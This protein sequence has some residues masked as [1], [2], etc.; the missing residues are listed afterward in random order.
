MIASSLRWVLISR[1]TPSKP[2]PVDRMMSDTSAAVACPAKEAPPAAAAAD[3]A[4]PARVG[5]VAPV[6]AAD[7]PRVHGDAAPLSRRGA[8]VPGVTSASPGCKAP[9]SAR[10]KPAPPNEEPAL[11]TTPAAP[12]DPLRRVSDEVGGE[13]RVAAAARRLL[14]IGSVDCAATVG[15]GSVVRGPALGVLCPSTARCC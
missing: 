4:P 14:L 13:Q 7:L 12:V 9:P 10:A 8:A 15:V 2:T 5:G 6:A 1:R 3:E 11:A